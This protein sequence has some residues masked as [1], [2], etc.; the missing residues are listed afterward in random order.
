MLL[1]GTITDPEEHAHFRVG[2]SQC[3]PVQHLG[4]AAAE[5]EPLQGG[6][7][8]TVLWVANMRPYGE[9]G[10]AVANLDDD[11]YA[12]L[13]LWGAFNMLTVLERDGTIPVYIQPH[14]LIPGLNNFRINER[15]PEERDERFD[16]FVYRASDGTFDSNDATVDLTILPPG[17]PPQILSAPVTVATVG[18]LYAYQVLTA[19]PD[20]GDVPTFA[21]STAPAGMTI[22]PATG[23]IRWTPDGSQIGEH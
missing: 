14:W 23:L 16:Q 18:F 19:D 20:P 6:G 3:D 1:Y 8:G 11:P 17:N 13:V 10:T 12:E 9:T 2:F 15:L 5:A 7:R 22:N 4:F 21:L